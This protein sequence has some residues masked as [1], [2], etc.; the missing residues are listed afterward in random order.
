M[1]LT[2]TVEQRGAF[3]SQEL[4]GIQMSVIDNQKWFYVKRDWTLG[5]YDKPTTIWAI[6]CEYIYRLFKSPY[7]NLER[8]VTNLMEHLN[9][10]L[11]DEKDEGRLKQFL[12]THT[13]ALNALYQAYFKLQ[14][15]GRI[16]DFGLEENSKL[17]QLVLCESEN[18]IAV[19]EVQNKQ[20]KDLSVVWKNTFPGSPE[21]SQEIPVGETRKMLLEGRLGH[22]WE[23]HIG[24]ISETVSFKYAQGWYKLIFDPQEI[25][26]E[27][28][29]LS[30]RIHKSM[31]F[32]NCKD[33]ECQVIFSI[34][35]EIQTKESASE[36][37]GSLVVQNDHNCVVQAKFAFFN[38]HNLAYQ[39]TMTV[40]D[41]EKHKKVLEEI[42][43][44]ANL[45]D[46]SCEVV[47][48]EYGRVY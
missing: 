19:V 18:N 20:G 36:G 9:A 28:E 10:Y 43:T 40:R 8:Q 11:A 13:V 29:P 17:W 35:G 30:S 34:N 32:E 37:S 44:F 47:L 27:S 46:I 42:D 39:G 23:F 6:I 24:N 1:S 2:L 16:G 31:R 22:P 48:R 7:W 33:K 41:K 25:K 38:H 12:S 21:C 4:E 14:K 26:V 5:L 45:E 15:R 3:L